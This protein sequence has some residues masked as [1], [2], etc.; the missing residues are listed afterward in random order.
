MY[1]CMT[2]FGAVVFGCVVSSPGLQSLPGGVSVMAAT[3][4]A[5]LAALVLGVFAGMF[6][7]D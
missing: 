3:S 1:V 2:L 6:L 4:L 7:E 5:V